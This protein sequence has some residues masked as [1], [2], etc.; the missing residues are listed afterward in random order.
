[1]EW[2][3]SVTQQEGKNLT[4]EV[5]AANTAHKKE[6]GEAQQATLD[7]DKVL[8]IMEDWLSDFIA[9]SRIALENKPQLL[10]KMGVVEPS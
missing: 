7:R 6:K 9:I 1:M 3:K 2:L 8:D 5:E 10:E 4:D